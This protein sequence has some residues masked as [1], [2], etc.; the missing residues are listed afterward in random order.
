MACLSKAIPCRYLASLERLRYH[1]PA[2]GPPAFWRPP[3]TAEDT[4]AAATQVRPRVFYGWYIVGASALSNALLSGIVYSGFGAFIIPIE[5]TFGWSRSVISGA[6]ALRQFESGLLAPVV[7]FVVDRVGARRII[8]GGA[9]MT[10]LGL[11]A[12]GYLTTGLVSFYIFFIIVAVGTSGVSHAVTWPVIIS[13]WFRRQRGLAV[14]LAVTGPTFGTS[15][16]ILNTSLEEQ[17]GWRSVVAG[18]GIVVIVVVSLL[19]LVARERPEP[20]GL[21]PDG[22]PIV[23]TGS[24]L[25]AGPAEHIQDAGMDF[26]SVLR[27]RSF[28]LLTLYL[29][30]MFIS[31]AGFLA[32]EQVY[33]VD[34]LGF[35]ARGAAVMV[36]LTFLFSAI[37]RIGA[38]LLMDRVDYRLVMAGASLLLTFSLAYAQFIDV[39]TGWT[40]LPFIFGFGVA[41]GSNI[42][43]RTVLGS[44]MFGNRALGSIVGILNGATVGAGLIGPLMLGIIFDWRGAYTF[45]IWIMVVLSAMLTAVPFL[46]RSRQALV[47]AREAAIL[48]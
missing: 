42:P 21:R 1:V 45:G 39:R 14:G 8:V 2:A 33:F 3:L 5:A 10:G 22:D 46:M 15:L 37:G 11:V 35:S 38:G 18:Y 28:W 24:E 40:A 17:F 13:R 7:G 16:I 43:M 6:I 32:H 48:A 34:D 31:T 25:V 44:E 23:Q 27:R 41:F 19:G 30:G 9:L 20:Y 29:G 47:E 36:T 12:L 26:S 4:P